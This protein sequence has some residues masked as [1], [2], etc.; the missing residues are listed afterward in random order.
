MRLP[1]RVTP[2]AVSFALAIGLVLGQRPAPA[3]IRGTAAQLVAI[4]EYI[5]TTWHTL[6]RSNANVAVAAVDPKFKP[7]P[8]GRWPVYV[9]QRENLAAV[10][11]QLKKAMPAAAWATV[12]L[13]R[14][15]ERAESAAPG[16]LYLPLPYVVPGG[17]FNEMY[18]WDSF[19]IQL[20]LLRDGEIRM[21]T[22][23]ADNFLYEIRNYGKILNANRTYYLGRSQPPFLT[24]M[25]L[26]VYRRTKDKE[27]LR[28]AIPASEAYYQY[29]IAGAASDSADGPFAVFRHRRGARARI[30]VR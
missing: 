4:E 10:E 9:S 19:F 28:A 27:W 13:R 6:T 23:M 7:E 18:G 14:L 16:L 15:P 1:A 29:W 20:G 11:L 12:A 30:L 2:V 24:E 3:P 5:H 17:R 21:A 22:D 25:L 8:G 26:G